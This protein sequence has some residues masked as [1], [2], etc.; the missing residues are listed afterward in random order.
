MKPDHLPNNCLYE[1]TDN[2]INVHAHRLGTMSLQQLLRD[3]QTNAPEVMITP[4]MWVGYEN[5]I[6]I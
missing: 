4:E 2:L 3:G 5:L 6:T 1:I